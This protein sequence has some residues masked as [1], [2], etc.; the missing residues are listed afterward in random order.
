MRPTLAPVLVLLV[1]CEPTRPA[2]PDAGPDAPL[3]D[4]PSVPDAGACGAFGGAYV[5]TTTCPGISVGSFA[6]CVAQRDCSGTIHLGVADGSATFELDGARGTF[7]DPSLPAG[8]SCDRVDVGGGQLELE[9]TDRGGIGCTMTLVRRS[10]EAEGLCCTGSADC[11]SGAGCTLVPIGGGLPETTACVDRED[12]PRAVGESC[13]RSA[14]G[15]DDCAADLFCT[16][17]GVAAGLACRTLCRGA[18]D[19]A[20]GEVCASAGTAPR[21]GT[22][23]DGCDPFDGAAC[24]PGLGCQPTPL[25]GDPSLGTACAVAGA[26]ALGELCE[27]TGCQPGLFCRRNELLEL[28][29]A[30]PC[31]AAHPCASG[32][33]APLDDGVELGTCS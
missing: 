12:T 7:S 4:A 33:C 26:A 3:A 22:C 29:C 17:L 23:L 31:D 13:T 25:L 28:R 24:G 10:F 27:A 19:C 9:C 2:P 21:M 5:G 30:T 8:V 1:A 11:A 20:V 18:T 6:A 14:P 16:P 32:T 15:Q